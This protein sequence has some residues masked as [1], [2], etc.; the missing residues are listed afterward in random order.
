MS[1]GLWLSL[2]L[3]FA[4]I[5]IEVTA[6]QWMAPLLEDARHI[7]H[8]VAGLSVSAFWAGITSGRLLLARL[9]LTQ[10][11]LVAGTAGVAVLFAL[12]AVAPKPVVL[13]LMFLAG[14]ALSPTT[15]TLFA[16]T[17]DR[18]G[19]A[20]AQKVSGWQLLSAN[21]AG[22]GLP[23]LTGILVGAVS[24]FAPAAVLVV[25]ASSG[26]I[27]LAIVYARPTPDHG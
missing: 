1:I 26:A 10:R 24:A 16:H 27:L 17:A 3:F 11:M 8:R 13:P 19:A 20:L 22:I 9:H 2:G 12:T 6:G 15:P 7:D 5:G 18:V 4:F 25:T 23:A 14:L 21:V